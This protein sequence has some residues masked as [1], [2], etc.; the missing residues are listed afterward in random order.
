MK[1]PGR[2]RFLCVLGATAAA[3]ATGFARGAAV[4]ILRWRGVLMG[5]EV[6]IALGGLDR[7][8]A[9]P[10]I[11]ACAAEAARLEQLFSLQRADSALSR[12]NAAGAIAA[13]PAEFLELIG[14]AQVLA[15]RTGGAFDP[16]VQPLW[17]LYRAHF[18]QQQGAAA[19]PP[20]R[21]VRAALGRVGY[22]RLTVTPERVALG[23]PGMALT[24]NGIAQGYI[25]DRLAALLRARGVEHVLVDM[26]EH[27]GL[28]SHP[29]HRPWRVAIRDPRQ[30][31]GLLA[32]VPLTDRALAT[33]GGYGLSFD[34]AGRF[35]HLFDP[36]TGDCTRRYLSV[37][38]AHPSATI[39]DALSTAFSAMPREAIAA[40]VRAEPALEVWLVAPDGALSVLGGA[41]RRA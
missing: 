28:G 33:S 40:L 29:D 12:L 27:Y 14:A 17:T 26:G 31:T 41:K 4:P 5:A 25:T 10:L 19:G 16:T 15:R 3:A 9:A 37:S 23:Q 7:Q 32:E 2:R 8:A 1:R 20:A 35:H 24:L 36:R 30:V 18:A 38:V 13:P 11:A 6:S 39:A 21:A 22:T 34:S